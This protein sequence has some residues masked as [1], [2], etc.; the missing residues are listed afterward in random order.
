V[1]ALCCYLLVHQHLPVDRAAQ[2]L[3]DVL[4]APL[5]TGTVAAVLAEGTAG[6][7]RFCQVVREQLAVAEVTHFDETGARVA[8][9]LHWVH[10]ASTSSLSLFT[11]HARRGKV[12]MDAAGVL[13]SVTGVAVHDGWSPYWRYQVTHALCGTHLL[14]ELEVIVDEPGQGWAAGMAELLADAKTQADRARAAGTERVD[15]GVRLRLHA[16]YQRLLADGQA[17]TDA[18]AWLLAVS[19][20]ATTPD[21][22]IPAGRCSGQTPSG[23]ATT[24]TAQQQGLRGPPR[25]YGRAWPSPRQS[26]AGGTPPSSWRLGALP[27]SDQTGGE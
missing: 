14:R 26:A 27:S 12:A 18:V 20:T 10:S 5:A 13:P 11:V 7:E 24:R 9:R 4:G 23:R 1:R 2:L 19:T 15:D 8:G 16:R 21:L 6:L 25:C 3:G 22:A 17:A